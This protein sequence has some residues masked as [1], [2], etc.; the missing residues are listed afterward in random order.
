MLLKET[1][2]DVLNIREYEEHGTQRS[3][4]DSDGHTSV[5][6]WFHTNEDGEIGVVGFD[7]SDRH[8]CVYHQQ[9]SGSVVVYPSH[10]RYDE[11]P[12]PEVE[13][14]PSPSDQDPILGKVI[15]VWDISEVLS[16]NP[17]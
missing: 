12:F 15:A 2:H 14:E 3:L 17:F 9:N 1:N 7:K 16:D 8:S 4:Y 11:F 6:C 10:P 13:V 5:R